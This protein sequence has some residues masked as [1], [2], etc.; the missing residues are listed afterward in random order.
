MKPSRGSPLALLCSAALALLLARAS[1]SKACARANGITGAA[2]PGS[3]RYSALDQIDATNAH[4][5]EIAW[6]WQSLPA[7]DSPT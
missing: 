3:T 4:E 6:R 7:E 1:H 5:L 2:M